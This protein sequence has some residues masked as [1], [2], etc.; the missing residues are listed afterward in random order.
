M[1]SNNSTLNQS[2]DCSVLR[3][4]GIYLVSWLVILIMVEKQRDL[5]INSETNQLFQKV[6]FFLKYF[7]SVCE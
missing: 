1:K 3:I 7:L 4:T 2:R 5:M 6:E